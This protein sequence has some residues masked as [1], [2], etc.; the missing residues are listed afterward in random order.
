[1]RKKTIVIAM[2]ALY[3]YNS[4][5]MAY[6]IDLHTST[7][8]TVYHMWSQWLYALQLPHVAHSYCGVNHRTDF[9]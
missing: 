1:M 4:A 6:C 8:Y 5:Q 3:R 7:L 2:T 9:I